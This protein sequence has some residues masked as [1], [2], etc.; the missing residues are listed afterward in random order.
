MS[1]P[2]NKPLREWP[3]DLWLKTA[4]RG[5]GLSPCAFWNMSVR[6]WLTL[7]ASNEVQGLAR[8]ELCTLMN[9]YPDE[10]LHD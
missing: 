5:F 2:L 1:E 8:A 10:K 4:V 3:F 9:T 6:D 7:L